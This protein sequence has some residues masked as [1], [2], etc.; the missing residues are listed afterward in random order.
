MRYYVSYWSNGRKQTIEWN[1]INL[2][3]HIKQSRVNEDSIYGLLL[4]DVFGYE[5][6]IY[7]FL[8]M[9]CLVWKREKKWKERNILHIFGTTFGIREEKKKLLIILKF[10]KIPII[11]KKKFIKPLSTTNTITLL[12]HYQQVLISKSSNQ[13]LSL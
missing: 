5:N 4:N 2:L 11:N 6:S 3:M 9:M 1:K 13:S 12:L 7:G 10:T 8:L